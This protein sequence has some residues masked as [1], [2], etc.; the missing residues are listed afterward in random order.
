MT[1]QIKLLSPSLHNFTTFPTSLELLS[2]PCITWWMGVKGGMGKFLL[3]PFYFGCC[4][5]LLIWE[6]SFN[7]LLIYVLEFQLWLFFVS[8]FQIFLSNFLGYSALSGICAQCPAIK[9]ARNWKYAFRLFY[10]GYKF[11]FLS[12]WFLALTSVFPFGFRIFGFQLCVRW[13]HSGQP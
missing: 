4:C 5:F 13:A 9:A 8:W 6:F 1:F 10:V 3:D 12:L 2:S 7:K 11:S